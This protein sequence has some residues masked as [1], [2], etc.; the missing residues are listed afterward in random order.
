[1]VTIQTIHYEVNY[2]VN[3]SVDGNTTTDGTVGHERIS[4]NILIKAD[5]DISMK[6]DTRHAVCIDCT[7]H[8]GHDLRN[9]VILCIRNNAL[10]QRVESNIVLYPW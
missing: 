5:T 7:C 10:Q 6:G 2:M 9:A 8:Y 3:S 1:M 4:H